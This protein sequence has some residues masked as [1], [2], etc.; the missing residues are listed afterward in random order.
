MDTAEAKGRGSDEERLTE[1]EL[2]GLAF[3]REGIRRLVDTVAP[4]AA[5]HE[6]RGDSSGEE[7][8]V[9]KPAEAGKR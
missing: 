3:T 4:E 9:S 7:A 1:P 8:A 5:T 2:G 6:T